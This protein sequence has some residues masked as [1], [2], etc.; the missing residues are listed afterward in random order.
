MNIT[1]DSAIK[2]KPSGSTLESDEE[3]VNRLLRWLGVSEASTSESN[4]RTE[5]KEDYDFYAGKQDD[6][7]V[8]ERLA[9][10]KR[11]A[12]VYNECKPKIDMLIGLAAQTKKAPTVFP[13]ETSDEGLAEIANGAFK[14]FRRKAR[15]ARNEIECFE[16]TA[17]SGRSLLHFYISGEDPFKPEIKSKRIHGRD[18]WLDPVSVEYDMSD[19]R[20]IFVDKWFDKDE[21]KAL[22]PD[23]NPDEISQYSQS[24]PDLPSFFSQEREKYRVTECWYR[25][26][27]EVF[28]IKNPLTSRSE[29][30]TRQQFLEFKKKVSQGITLPNGQQFP[31]EA[32]NNYQKKWRKNVYYCFF[33]SNKVIERGKSPYTHNEFPFILFGGYKD[34]DE[35]RWFGAVSM[36]KDPQRGINTMRRQ[37]QHLLQTS[38]KNILIHEVGAVLDIDEYEKRSSEPGYHMEVAQGVLSPNKKIDFTTQP[39]IS[40]VYAQLFDM[41]SQTMKDAS[42][43]Q[44]SLLGIQ[45]TSREPG[46]T[47]RMRQETGLAV[48]FLLFDNYRESKLQGGRQLLSMIQQY[49]TDEELIRIEGEE[50]AKMIAINTQKNKQAPGFNDISIGKYD[51]VIE[52]SLENATMRMATLQM[53]ADFGQQNPGSIPPEMIIEYSDLPLS[54]KLQVKNYRLEQQKIQQQEVQMK[55]QM[56]QSK[57]QVDQ[58]KI[59]VDAQLKHM[60]MALEEKI[61]VMDNNVK[62]LIEEIKQS[63][64][65]KKE[66]E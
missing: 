33:S 5:S 15:I 4:W 21:L 35:N 13:V 49:V 46:I 27:D 47:V 45:T 30:L 66:R 9:A 18:F 50:G 11:P 19:A 43:I 37:L 53:L 56:E 48:L 29:A 23:L 6:S 34:D 55:V 28:W 3:L 8:L 41:D 26:Y 22:F 36:M 64:A 2:T 12:S 52:E 59:T 42:G 14:H 44:D 61:A 60:E 58:A 16:H 54:A 31:N 38:P 57:V 17:K 7:E 24:H 1:D 32:V 10:L 40:P 63:N 51:L 62:I 39:Q 25:Q 20:F 65:S